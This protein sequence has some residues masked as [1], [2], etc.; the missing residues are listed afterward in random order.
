MS[1]FNNCY[2]SLE[3]SVEM[4]PTK[5]SILESVFLT[6]SDLI[7]TSQSFLLFILDRYYTNVGVIGDEIFPILISSSVCTKIAIGIE[8]ECLCEL[9]Q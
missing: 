5:S 8:P 1:I 7:C 3:R 6:P 4:R 2:N 9:D